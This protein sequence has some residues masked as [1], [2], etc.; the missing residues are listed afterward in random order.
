MSLIRTI[1]LIAA[2]L[3]LSER[4]YSQDTAAA[5]V[6]GKYINEVSAK[7]AALESRLDK[8]TGKA[9]QRLQRQEEKIQKKLARLDSSKAKAL[10][11]NTR[12]SYAGLQQKLESSSGKLKQYIPGLDSMGSSL[13]FL[14]DNPPLISTAKEIKEKT[15]AALEK[16]KGLQQQFAKAEDVKAFLQQ[17]KQYLKEQLQNTGLVKQLKKVNK[18]V[19]YYSAQVSEYRELLNDHKKATR[20]ALQ[21]LSKTRAFQQFMRKHSQLAGLFRLPDPATPGTAASLAGL[22]T[23]ARVNN[24]IQSQLSSPQARAQFSQHLQEAQA[25]LNQLKEKFLKA[26]FKGGGQ[27]EAGAEGFTPNTQKTK[28]FWKRIE[29]GTNFQSQRGNGLLPVTSDIG[30]SIGYRLNDKSIIGIGGSYKVG[31]GES[32]RKIRV[33]HQGM[34]VRSFIDWKVK[35]SF[36]VTGGYE[37]NYRAALSEVEIADPA[38]ALMHLQSWQQS[39]LLGISKQLSLKTKFFKQTKLQVLWDMLSYRQVPRTPAVVVRVGYGF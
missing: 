8:K 35:G 30:L 1:L 9:L 21:L 3:F 32:I 29:L 20:K 12:Q 27:G 4:G 22:Q 39:G 10:L 19:Y 33:T 26:P 36:W 25:E 37:W 6:P 13:R 14:Q 2:C 17:R 11:E 23:R 5:L 24:L 7:A 31:W 28:S 15:T 18:E 38:G 34:S 16:V